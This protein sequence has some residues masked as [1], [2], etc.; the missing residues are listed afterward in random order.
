MCAKHGTNLASGICYA[1]Y[2]DPSYEAAMREILYEQALEYMAEGLG[3]ED[4]TDSFL[5]AIMK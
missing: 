1:L 4:L 3:K 5:F 2:M